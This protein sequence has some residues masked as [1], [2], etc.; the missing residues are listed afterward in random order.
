MFIVQHFYVLFDRENA[1]GRFTVASLSQIGELACTG[2]SLTPSIPG[3][4]GQG[5]PAANATQ[6]LLDLFTVGFSTLEAAAVDDDCFILSQEAADY[7]DL[8]N[9]PNLVAK[10]TASLQG[11]GLADPA[12]G[13]S[14][15]YCFSGTYLEP[16]KK[17]YLCFPPKPVRCDV[18]SDSCS[19]TGVYQG[20]DA[21][22]PIGHAMAATTQF[23]AKFTG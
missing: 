18:N 17:Y 19:N 22:S 14:R 4:N 8:D 3:P 5:S 7:G 11:P 10:S 2:Q 9:D 1:M 23:V 12:D 20:G 13:Y 6:V 16:G 21:I 15:T